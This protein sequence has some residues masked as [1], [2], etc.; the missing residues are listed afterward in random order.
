MP[1]TACWSGFKAEKIDFWSRQGADSGTQNL[2][3]IRDFVNG[4][5]TK[6]ARFVPPLA[7]LVVTYHKVRS[8]GKVVCP[9]RD[10]FK[11][12]VHNEPFFVKGFFAYSQMGAIAECPFLNMPAYRNMT[13]MW[14]AI[15]QL[16]IIPVTFSLVN[17]VDSS[18]AAEVSRPVDR[19]EAVSLTGILVGVVLSA[20]M[21]LLSAEL[22][23]S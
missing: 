11:H 19:G 10:L 5:S 12:S 14:A 9:Y 2:R 13:E 21:V 1:D 18:D 4:L 7:W 23:Y 15:C 8:L 17:V 16:W 20:E 3:H 6:G 22:K